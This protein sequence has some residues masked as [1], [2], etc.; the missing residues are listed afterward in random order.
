MRT[1]TYGVACSLD[2]FIAGDGGV[3]DWLHFSPDVQELMATYWAT[4]DTILVGRKTWDVTAASGG[5]GDAPPGRVRRS[6]E[7]TTYVFSR[8]LTHIAQPGVH[9]S[10]RCR[11]IRARLEA[12]ARQGICSWAARARTFALR[13]DVI[14]DVDSTSTGVLGSGVPLFRDAGRRVSLELAENRTI[15]GGCVLAT[16]P[17]APL[18]LRR[19]EVR[20]PIDTAPAE[21]TRPSPL[22]G[23]R[24]P[25]CGPAAARRR[26][27]RV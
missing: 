7:L 19:P 16:V 11:S 27:L 13:A 25:G 22:G 12:E 3:I 4:V 2:G 14:D 8:T 21:S 23:G 5:A 10:R 6:A 9:W 26:R 1:V 15:D 20:A 17:G 18:G 24:C